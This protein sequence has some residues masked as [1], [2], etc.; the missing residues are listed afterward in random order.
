[1]RSCVRWAVCLCAI[2]VISARPAAADDEP[3]PTNL[4]VMHDLVADV[5]KELLASVPADVA[6]GSVTLSPYANDDI[7][8]FVGDV[9]TAVL[10]DAGHKVYQARQAPPDTTGTRAMTLEYQA[11]HFS[12]TYPKIYR[13]FLIGGK[14]VK[15]KASVGLSV[16][17]VDAT[18]Q[19]VAW[20]GDASKSYEDQ[21]SYGKL[22]EVEAGT[23]AFTK[24]PRSSTKWGKVVE[25]VVVSGIIIGL[26]YL[27]FANQNE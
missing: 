14:K 5:A 4:E 6:F 11:Q 2:A 16:K 26:I 20:I 13:P 10:T 22:A 24:P 19:S 15:R 3:V 18:D 25:P 27:F 17:L 1:M 9:L 21:F 23:L 12:L 7:Y 8:N